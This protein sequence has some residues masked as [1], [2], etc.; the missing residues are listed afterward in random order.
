[1]FSA[2]DRVVP[3]LFH[4][5]CSTQWEHCPSAQ[6]LIKRHI[7]TFCK[8][9][10]SDGPIQ[11][12]LIRAIILIRRKSLPL[13]FLAGLSKQLRNLTHSPLNA[14][15]NFL[16]AQQITTLEVYNN[17]QPN[18]RWI[19]SQFFALSTRLHA[20]RRRFCC[21]GEEKRVVQAFDCVCSAYNEI[22]QKWKTKWNPNDRLAFAI[23]CVVYNGDG[24]GDFLVPT[25]VETR[26]DGL[27][28]VE[29]VGTASSS[30]F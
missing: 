11:L 3:F 27:E 25:P 21:G 29:R 2:Q 24:A 17:R 10:N 5:N 18:K 20:D 14:R 7:P 16:L 26:S 9:M 1:M 6:Q 12:L 15:K 28:R 19:S 4:A 30:K 13:G 23:M 8:A 22:N